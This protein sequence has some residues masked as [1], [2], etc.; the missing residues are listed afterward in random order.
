METS[1]NAQRT[2]TVTMQL[3]KSTGNTHVYHEEGH[4]RA[5]QVFPTVYIQ[6]HVFGPN[7]AQAP[8]KIRVTVEF[9]S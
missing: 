1:N 6:K 9:G 2:K 8:D 3:M 7:G 5:K 4:E